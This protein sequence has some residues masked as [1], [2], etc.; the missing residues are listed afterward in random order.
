MNPTTQNEQRQ[1][2]LSEIRSELRSMWRL[3]GIESDAVIR[4]LSYNLIVYTSGDKLAVRQITD[5]LSPVSLIRPG[6]IV[7]VVSDAS[8][9]DE[10]QAWVMLHCQRQGAVQVCGETII[11]AVSENLREEIYSTVSSLLAPDVPA[12]L[13]WAECPDEDDPLYGKLA[14]EVDRV[15]VD[16]DRFGNP[17]DLVELAEQNRKTVS[18]LAWARLTPWRKHTA[19]LWDAPELHEALANLRTLDIVYVA[20]GDFANAGRALLML[21]WL[22]DRLEWDLVDAKTGPTGGFLSRWRKWR[23]EGKAEIVESAYEGMPPGEIM[24]VYL[25]AGKEPPFIMPRLEYFP[26]RQCIDIRLDDASPSARRHGARFSPMTTAEALMEEIE[27]QPHP[28]YRLALKRAAE[29]VKSAH[30][31]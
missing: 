12:Y 10:V 6:R 16:S 26:D 15:L 24:G 30:S 2:A 13:W 7:C 29:V 25:Q 18:D 22:A 9:N 1:V 11:V 5:Q 14:D 23:W 3:Q 20:G 17:Q 31:R 21:G 28:Y 8:S 4:S 27:H 19:S